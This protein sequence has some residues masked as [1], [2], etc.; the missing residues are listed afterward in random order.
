MDNGFIT[1]ITS[2]A[3]GFFLGCIIGYFLNILVRKWTYNHKLY[4]IDSKETTKT[5]LMIVVTVI[6]GTANLLALFNGNPVDI[7]VQTIFGM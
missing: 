7:S 2:F 5:L 1:S 4:G 6:W 3:I